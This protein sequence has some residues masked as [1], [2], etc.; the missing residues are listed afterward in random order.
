[1]PEAYYNV[2]VLG[3]VRL[4]LPELPTLLALQAHV[5]GITEAPPGPANLALTYNTVQAEVLCEECQHVTLGGV[6]SDVR[7]HDT[8]HL[9]YALCRRA[10]LQQGYGLFHAAALQMPDG[11][12]ILLAGHSGSGKTTISEH[13]R[14]H[15]AFNMLSGNK[16]LVQFAAD[17]FNVIAGTPVSSVLQPDGARQQSL[18]AQGHLPSPVKAIVLVRLNDGVSQWQQL[19]ELSALHTLLPLCLDSVNAD[20]LAAGTTLF[21]GT[22]SQSAK[23]KLADGL[24][25][26]LPSTPV[27][28][29]VGSLGYISK[30]I[31]G[32]A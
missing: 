23:Q 25:E 32:L 12:A 14:V 3:R 9:L 28:R 1:L 8:P 5:P 18:T 26:S 30:Q 16:T 13:M 21:D 19:P 24:R 20:I 31:R 7:V 15:D 11:K 17:Q 27:Y 29:A 10:W 6:W 4:D 22:I 2:P